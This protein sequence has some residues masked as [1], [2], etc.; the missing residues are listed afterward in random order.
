[1]GIRVIYWKSPIKTPAKK[2]RNVLCLKL[3]SR[4]PVST[5][6]MV[7]GYFLSM[8][9]VCQDYQFLTK[10]FTNILVFF[11]DEVTVVPSLFIRRRNKEVVTLFRTISHNGQKSTDWTSY[12]QEFRQFFL[13]VT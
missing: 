9:K 4:N 2:R 1:M 5:C 13:T 10:K 12:K 8:S 11:S 7:G 6:G 3:I